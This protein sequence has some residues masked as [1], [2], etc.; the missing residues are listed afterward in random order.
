MKS[1]KT[2]L[3]LSFLLLTFTITLAIGAISITSSYKSLKEEAEKSLQLLS[4]EGAKVTESR[5]D[6]L[7]ATLQIISMKKE[8]INMGYEVDLNV[9]KE[10]LGKT[11]FL[12][13]GYVLPNGYT[14]F[15]DGTVRLMSDRVYVQEALA[16][17]PTISDVIISR[18][19]RT[20][21][22]ELCIPVSKNGEVIGAVLARTAADSL[23]NIIQDSG[24]GENGYAFMINS[25]GNLIAHPDTQKIVER[26]NPI[27]EAEEDP[28]YASIAGAFQLMIAQ[29]SGLTRY[30]EN[31]M[32]YYAG[33][34]PINGTNWTFVI[35]A[36]ENEILEVIP[37]LISTIVTAMVVVIILSMGLVYI[38][39]LTITRPLVDMTKL[40]QKIT[41]LDLRDHITNKYVKQ[42][43]EIGIL[44]VSF[45]A[46]TLKLRE[47]ISQITDAASQ[48]TVTSN[49]LTG[50]SLQTAQVSEDIANTVEEIAKGASEQAHNTEQGSLQANLLSQL[51]KKNYGHMEDL[52]TASK[53]VNGI[54]TSGLESIHNL[55]LAT[56]DNKNA[57]ADILDVIIQTKTSSDQISEASKVITE[58]A[59]N[60]NLLAL[61]ATIEAARAGE[62]G[63]GFAVVA[64]EIQ[65]LSDES[66]VSAKHINEIISKLQKNTAK[67]SVSMKRMATTSEIQEKNVEETIHKYDSIAKTMKTS[68]SAIEELNLSEEKMSKVINEFLIM[69]DSLSAIAEQN[70]AG[71]QQAASAM[72]EQTASSR[73][74]A[75]VSERLSQ[76]G[77]NL[78][79]IT[80]Q[81][82]V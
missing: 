40:F 8:I 65:K 14:H 74:L 76:L 30:T 13:I 12:D 82:K 70:A 2:K 54:V 52:N 33:F 39:D 67:A 78:Q 60:T 23:S 64:G 18:V 36:S 72:E 79:K 26:F 49:E 41:E 25:D 5:M 31:N 37:T 1:I 32:N 3:I 17:N 59:R 27:K 68:I 10:E 51:L 62:A 34:T 22:I 42:K 66:A 19:T 73:D 47:V 50:A 57:T 80:F 61:N 7:M 9:L 56:T 20:S 75:D 58:I 48:V 24:Y 71:T 4:V 16:G 55:S 11:D 77:D 43:D 63:K 21:E 29:K 81:F 28:S 69:L 46:L 44:S 35:T 45:N 6:A 38:L 53:N 15:T